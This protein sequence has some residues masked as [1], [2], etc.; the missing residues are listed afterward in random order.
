M[1]HVR[2]GNRLSPTLHPEV[3]TR[4]AAVC[5]E[6]GWLFPRRCHAAGLR[7]PCR[8]PLTFLSC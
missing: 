7:L 3:G 1:A 4:A 6:G 2:L 8:G 5:V